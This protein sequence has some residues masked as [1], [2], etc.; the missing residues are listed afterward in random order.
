MPGFYVDDDTGR[1]HPVV[2]YDDTPDE[3]DVVR[4]HPEDIKAISQQVIDGLLAAKKARKPAKAKGEQYTEAFEHC[5]SKYPSRPGNS[6]RDA[7]KAFGARL[8]EGIEPNSLYE[9]TIK[10]AEHCDSEEK[11]G[12]NFVLQASTFYGPSY[13]FNDSWPVAVKKKQDEPWAKIPYENNDLDEFCKKHG[14]KMAGAGKSYAEW[15]RAIQREIDA[16]LNA[17]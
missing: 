13:R 3:V 4:L 1:V 11:T 15:R 7:Y 10:Y 2:P 8:L 17:E 9:K 6:K 14:Y 5:W 12:T 16:K